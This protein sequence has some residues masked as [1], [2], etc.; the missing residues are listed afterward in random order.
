MSS[1]E[2]A[3]T[4]TAFQGIDID[5]RSHLGNVVAF[6]T[7]QVW[8]DIVFAN[9]T[10]V[11]LWTGTAIN[12]SRRPLEVDHVRIKSM[13]VQNNLIYNVGGSDPNNTPISLKG[14]LLGSGI[15]FDT[16]NSLVIDHNV[17]AGSSKKLEYKGVRY[18]SFEDFNNAT[19]YRNNT[20]IIPTFV[21]YLADD[22]RLA[23]SDV[24]ARDKGADLSQYFNFD[25]DGNPR[26]QGGAWDIGAFEAV[27]G[28]A[29]AVS[30]LGNVLVALAMFQKLSVIRTWIGMLA[31]A[32]T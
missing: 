9:N 17:I 18:D 5:G 29:P 25:H 11:D 10:F 24:A 23:A 2:L 20:S 16:P 22:F 19:G 6:Q 4:G 15:I 30:T 31:P 1:L 12:H 27:G 28:G 3:K 14:D 32:K 8:D 7:E 13:I 26:P 21:N